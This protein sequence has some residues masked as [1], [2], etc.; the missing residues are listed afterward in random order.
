MSKTTAERQAAYR[1]RRPYAGDQG[2]GERRLNLWISTAAG[3]ALARLA[4]R[5]CVTQRP[6]I[7]RLLLAEDERILTELATDDAQWESYLNRGALRSNEPATPPWVPQKKRRK[8]WQHH[9]GAPYS[10]TA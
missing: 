6:I 8:T 5:Y 1:A 7:E 3:C 9:N 2:N 10:V 4:Q